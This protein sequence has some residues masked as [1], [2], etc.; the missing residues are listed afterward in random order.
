VPAVLLAAM[1]AADTTS[2]TREAASPPAE[3]T[4]TPGAAP[5]SGAATMRLPRAADTL[6]TRAEAIDTL[7]RGASPDQMIAK[8][9]EMDA[10]LRESEQGSDS[11]AELLH[12]VHEEE[13]ELRRIWPPGVSFFSGPLL[14]L[15]GWAGGSLFGY[16]VYPKPDTASIDE[17]CSAI[18][19]N[20]A[21]CAPTPVR[22]TA[23]PRQRRTGLMAK[24]RIR[25]NNLVR[26]VNR[27]VLAAP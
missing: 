11:I 7:A 22:V 18:L 23:V 1:A 12:E 16:T 14:G 21:C 24:H 26:R 19:G 20:P 6:E 3:S 25:V 27:S 10:A 15:P 8:C 4:D 5:D 9:R 2:I 17:A 13:S